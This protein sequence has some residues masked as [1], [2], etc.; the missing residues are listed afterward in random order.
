MRAEGRNC[1]YENEDDCFG[2]SY[3]KGA[4]KTLSYWDFPGGSVDKNL[5]ASTGD[6]GSVPGLGRFRMLWSK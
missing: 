1:F 3:R 6:M 4:S 5:H 2:K